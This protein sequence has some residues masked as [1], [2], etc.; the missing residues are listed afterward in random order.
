MLE[1]TSF[2]RVFED[3]GAGL[4][5]DESNESKSNTNTSAFESDD[6]IRRLIFCSGK[7]WINLVDH[8]GKQSTKIN[9]KSQYDDVLIISIEQI[10]HLI[11]FSVL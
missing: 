3:D 4:L 1:R 11:I 8:R 5:N 9:D 6:K 7:I 10:F 2:Q